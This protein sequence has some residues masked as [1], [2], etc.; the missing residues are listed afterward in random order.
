[1]EITKTIEENKATIRPEGWLDTKT[2]PQL[3]ELIESLLRL[4]IS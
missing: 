1:M 2:T 3:E 4:F